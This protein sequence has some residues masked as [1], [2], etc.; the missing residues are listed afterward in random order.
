MTI[1]K[2]IGGNQR[3]IQLFGLGR[4]IICIEKEV[5][6]KKVCPERFNGYT[7]MWSDNPE[8]IKNRC[9]K[10][11]GKEIALYVEKD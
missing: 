1:Y 11:I 2:L 6:G 8:D 4:D 7:S 3:A 9:E 10:W 5:N